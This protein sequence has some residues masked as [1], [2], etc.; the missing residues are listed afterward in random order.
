MTIGAQAG[1]TPVAAHQLTY[2]GSAD[3]GGGHTLLADLKVATVAILKAQL[4]IAVASRS[5]VEA[6]HGAIAVVPGIIQQR[7]VVDLPFAV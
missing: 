6:G 3:L 7:A 4:A 5:I 1:G 2:N